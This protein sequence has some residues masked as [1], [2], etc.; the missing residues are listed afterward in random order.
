[1]TIGAEGRAERPEIASL[2]SVI[3]AEV[4]RESKKEKDLVNLGKT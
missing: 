2:A 3:A 1:M 4:L